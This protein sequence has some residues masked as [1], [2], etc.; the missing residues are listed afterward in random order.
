M[1]QLYF[2]LIDKERN[3]YE[4]AQLFPQ[5]RRE[6]STYI[7]VLQDPS[8]GLPL[9]LKNSSAQGKREYQ[10]NDNVIDF[11]ESDTTSEEWK[12]M[13]EQFMNYHKSLSVY[14]LVNSAPIN[15]YLSLKT[16]MGLM[17]DKKVLDVGGG[18]G[19]AHCSFFQYPET[20]EYF[21]LDPNLRLLHDQFFRIY[22]KLSFLKMAHILAN[23]EYLPI[24][25]Q[26][27][28]V[29][30]NL[31]A[32][33]HFNDYK[34][35]ISEAYRVLKNGGTFF[36]TSHLDVPESDEDSTKLKSKLFSLSFFER[37]TR[38]LYYR[39]YAVGSDDHTLHLENENPIKEALLKVGFKIQQQEV[40]KRH[41]YFVA[42]KE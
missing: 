29:V 33:D 28:D 16:G 24:K 37:L 23:A 11:T 8:T 1:S 36:I 39:K 41:F 3:V 25:D 6:V 27:F 10:I 35:F 26:S 17:K 42:I 19:H 31:S 14:T 5:N 21:L 4:L 32:V 9:V 34:K 30:L 22:P 18:T 7:D 38:Y 20:I 12:R 2:D 40:F 15:N 13:N